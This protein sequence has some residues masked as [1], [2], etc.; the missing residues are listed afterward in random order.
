MGAQQ[1]QDNWI[2]QFLISYLIG[3]SDD[4]QVNDYTLGSLG[5]D[6]QI[7]EN[8]SEKGIQKIHCTHAKMLQTPG[9]SGSNTWLCPSGMSDGGWAKSEEA[10]TPSCSSSTHLLPTLEAPF[11]WLQSLNSDEVCET[12]H[13]H[14]ISDI[15]WNENLLDQFQLIPNVTCILQ[16]EHQSS[17]QPWYCLKCGVGLWAEKL[18]KWPVGDWVGAWLYCCCAYLGIDL[19]SSLFGVLLASPVLNIVLTSPLLSSLNYSCPSK[20]DWNPAFC[21]RLNLILAFH[22]VPQH[23]QRWAM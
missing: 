11:W 7:S 15:F 16:A 20:T 22:L 5:K 14:I 2:W 17:L 3:A 1:N 12:P 10:K 6:L 21:W 13:R 19:A 23:M 4:F 9:L 8:G 18:A